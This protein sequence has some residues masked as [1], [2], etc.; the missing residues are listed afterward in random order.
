MIR[1]HTLDSI[2]QDSIA[3]INRLLGHDLPEN[4]QSGKQCLLRV[5]C[6]GLCQAGG[7][8][9]ALPAAVSYVHE[10]GS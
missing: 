3:L 10:C 2:L 7:T 5:A 6:A 1:E 9:Q 4:K 8:L